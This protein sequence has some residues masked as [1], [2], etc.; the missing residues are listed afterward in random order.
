MLKFTQNK[1]DEYHI[2]AVYID[3]LMVLQQN[4][5][6]TVLEKMIYLHISFYR[7]PFSSD[8]MQW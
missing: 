5:V 2:H 8:Y 3:Y 4:L 1:L 6:P 7:G